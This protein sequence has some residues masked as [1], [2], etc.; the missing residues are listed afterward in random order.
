MSAVAHA[1]VDV[2]RAAEAIA[3]RHATASAGETDAAVAV[4]ALWALDAINAARLSHEDA[5]ASLTTLWAR[6]TDRQSG[7]GVSDDTHEL[8]LEGGWLHDDAIDR[9]PDL[10]EIRRLAVGILRGRRA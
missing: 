9:A 1:A 3:D 10:L 2:R 5:T 8:L 4:L 7:P 6:V